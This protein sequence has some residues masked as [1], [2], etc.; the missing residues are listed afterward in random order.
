LLQVDSWWR[1]CDQGVLTRKPGGCTRRRK[2]RF[3]VG[4]SLNVFQAH[5][6]FHGNDQTLI[7]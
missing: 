2:P 7:T 4:H 5:F 3:A 6:N 1:G